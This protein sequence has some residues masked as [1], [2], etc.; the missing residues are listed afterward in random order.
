MAVRIDLEVRNERRY[1]IRDCQKRTQISPFLFQ[2]E[3][4]APHPFL[5]RLVIVT[6][7]G[8]LDRFLQGWHVIESTVA[9]RRVVE[10][11]LVEI[12]RF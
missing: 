8:F 12:T 7:Y 6:F 4:T 10:T 5:E 2:N 11:A 9:E 1:L 3:R